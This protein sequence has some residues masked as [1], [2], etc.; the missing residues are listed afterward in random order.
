MLEIK[1]VMNI[2]API[3]HVWSVLV[4]R[5]SYAQWNPVILSQ[6]GELRRGCQA[7]MRINPV[8]LPMNV[9]IIYRQVIENKELSWF[10]GPPLVKGFHYFRLEAI[11]SEN[12]QLVHGEKFGLLAALLSWPVVLTLVKSNYYKADEALKLRCEAL[13]QSLVASSG[14]GLRRVDY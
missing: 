5:E 7:T 12:T 10:G 6:V 14:A 1:N 13:F 3:E 11:D 4:D 2:C 9:S 8:I